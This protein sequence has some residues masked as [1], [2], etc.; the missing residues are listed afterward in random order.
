MCRSPCGSPAVS[1]G[2]W[3]TAFPPQGLWGG[4]CTPGCCW[5]WGR[6]RRVRSM[7]GGG[8]KGGTPA[9][10]APLLPLSCRP[11]R[12]PAAAVHEHSPSDSFPGRGKKGQARVPPANTFSK[13][14]YKRPLLI[15]ML[16]PQC[17]PAPFRLPCPKRQKGW[18]LG[19]QCCLQ[20]ASL[21]RLDPAPAPRST[22]HPG[23][24]CAGQHPSC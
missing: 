9:H 4:R 18:V 13:A 7:G 8:E 22:S 15:L 5:S 19:D 17:P 10:V 2:C 12:C 20:G 24:G 1:P 23:L 21:P 11:A 3:V 16:L 14:A 6:F